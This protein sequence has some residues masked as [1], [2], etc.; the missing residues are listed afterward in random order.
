[1]SDRGTGR[2]LEQAVR[3][4][5]A[6]VV[7]ARSERFPSLALVSGYQRLYFPNGTFPNLADARENW[8]IGLS[9]TFS[10]FSGGRIK[11]GELIAQAALD[12]ARAQLRQTREF[13]ALD[14]RVALSALSQAEAAWEASR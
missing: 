11:G 7:I 5:E 3:A 8:T 2:E 6:Q 13:A 14:T 1:V 12:Q 9:T 4:Q 10:L